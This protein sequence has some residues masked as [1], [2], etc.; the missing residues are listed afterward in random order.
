VPPISHHYNPQVYLRQFVNP[1][2]KNEL[3]EFDLLTGTAKKS[4]PKD[5]GCEDF[6]HSF[7]REDGSRDDET[8]EKSFHTLENNLPKLFECIRHSRPLSE[9]VFSS[10]MT[11]AAL[12]RARCPMAVHSIQEG[13][14]KVYQYAFDVMKHSPNFEKAMVEK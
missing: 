1:A 6:Y 9:Q 8:I 12:Q 11:F 13:M 2:R 14:S 10:L 5:C 3:W 4:K 7:T